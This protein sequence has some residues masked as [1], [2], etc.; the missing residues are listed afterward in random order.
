MKSQ[1]L[2]P[3]LGST[4]ILLWLEGKPAFRGRRQ[5]PV[6]YAFFSPMRLDFLSSAFENL[7]I[8][9]ADKWSLFIQEGEKKE[10]ENKPMTAVYEMC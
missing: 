8:D 7:K 4:A 3:A 6:L 10:L 1:M 5:A 9:D 2:Q